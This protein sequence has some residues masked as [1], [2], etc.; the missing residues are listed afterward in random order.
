MSD[1]ESSTRRTADVELEMPA[2]RQSVTVARQAFSGI[3]D[4]TGWDESFVADVKIALSEACSNVV[5][6]AYPDG[7]PGPLLIRM[8][9]DHDRLVVLV[10][11]EGSGITPNVSKGAGLGLGLPLMAALSDEVQM[12]SSPDGA[13]EVEMTFS[14][15]RSEAAA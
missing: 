12:R 7:E 2:T 11:D 5:V 9:L 13:T 6:H 10:C 14:I 15:A 1:H 8:W 3:A 4:V